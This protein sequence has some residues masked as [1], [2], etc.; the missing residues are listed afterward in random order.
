MFITKY[1]KAMEEDS[2][3]EVL[4]LFPP[5]LNF[6]LLPIILLSPWRSAVKRISKYITYFFFWVENCIFIVLFFLYMLAHDP[7]IY[8]KTIF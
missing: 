7:F 3:Y 8:V 1:M 2:G 6:I 5:P 4:I